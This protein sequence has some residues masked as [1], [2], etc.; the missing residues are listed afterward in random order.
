M[1]RRSTSR[2]S[3]R[4]FAR[5][6]ILA[7]AAGLAAAP[8]L[9]LAQDDEREEIVVTGSRILQSNNN[10]AVPMRTVDSVQI[11]LSGQANV[12]DIIRELPA[13]GLSALTPSNSNFVVQGAGIQTV[14]LRNLGEDRTLVLV[15][16]RR[17]VSG[18]PG[19][20]I[21]DFNSIPTDFIERIDVIT[22]G[23]SAIY[24]SDA[25]A[26]AV[27]IILKDDFEGVSVSGQFGQTLENK[28]NQK[29]SFRVTA[30]SSFADGRGHAIVNAS[31]SQE[32]GVF[33]RD[34]DITA[35]DCTNLAFF[36]DDPADGK[37]C[38]T[39]TF[40]SFPPNT[41]IIIPTGDNT[42]GNR[43]I[44]PA[45]G[46]VRPFVSTEDGF[47]RQS[48]R[49]L[50]TPLERV[51]L[52]TVAEYEIAPYANFFIE[53]TYARTEATSELEP[54]P[55][56]SQDVFGGSLPFCF[57]TNDNDLADT[58]DLSTGVLLSSGVVPQAVRDAVLAAN[59]E[60]TADGAVIGF[61]RRL[62]EVGNRGAS[63]TR[64]TFRIVGGLD[65]DLMEFVEGDFFKS[66]NYE[67]SFNYG[68][69]TENQ[70]SSGQLNVS[71]LREAFNIEDDGAGGVRCANP[72][73]RGEGCVP[74]FIFGQNT[75]NSEA[76]AYI[77][78]PSLRDIEIEQTVGN[79][80]IT[81][82]FGKLP[83]GDAIGFSTG[84]EWRR[85]RSVDIP[86]ALSQTG[87]NAGN[88]QPVQKGSFNV[89]EGFAEIELPIVTG[90]QFFENLTLRGAVRVSDYS[91]VGT[92]VAWSSG[93]EWTPVESVRFRGQYA[94]AVRAP[95]I[96]ELFSA[97][98]E[99]FATVN[100]P[101]AGVTINQATNNPA[102][103]NTTLDINN[104]QNVLNSGVDATTDNS[105]LAQ[106]CLADPIVASRVARDGGFA[107][108]QPEFQ[109]T[110]GFVGGSPPIGTLTEETSR[111]YTIGGVITPRLGNEWIDAFA[112]SVD[113]FNIDIDDAIGI[114]GRQT[115]L[116]FCYS[117]TELSFGSNNQFCSNVVR[118]GMG[119]QIGALNEVNGGTLNIANRHTE[120][121]DAQMNYELGLDRVPGF[122]NMGSPG[123]LFFNATYTYLINLRRSQFG[124]TIDE[125][126]LIG[127]SKHRALVNV[128]YENGPLTF[129][130]D[131]T[132][133]GPAGIDFFEDGDRAVHFKT[134]TFT[135]LQLRYR[136]RDDKVTLVAGIDNVFDNFVPVGGAGGDLGQPVG[137]RTFPEVYEP[138]GRAFY[139]GGR[140]DF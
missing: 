50:S 3:D 54:F 31:W 41:R 88:V 60:L 44:D 55:L 116:D 13:A 134:Q 46:Q 65:G 14:N 53:G 121:V 71:N 103:F 135:D 75:I 84:V 132:I 12:A 122:R 130:A 128:V 4:L 16:G 113:Y 86:D 8:G 138:F 43:V 70:I 24:G 9:A 93:A 90:R 105:L 117:P 94:K 119:P 49:A 40:S 72:V 61:A 22:G 32:E 45:T 30:G 39:P 2:R 52:S 109:G 111:S 120:G 98:G 25:L 127:S 18:L 114:V 6:S 107:I 96:G 85:E 77:N 67:A 126:G 133:I 78:A 92:T 99:T 37:D 102:F 57:D 64:Q 73:A 100:D 118:F 15:N 28:D 131:T 47:N 17:F 83:L 48:V 137:A 104:P 79:A 51:L 10:S 68:T 81:S 124:E 36:T 125:E 89:F 42:V 136:I 11:D 1:L 97:G 91:T 59:P 27:N 82:R 87:Q 19:S 21:V 35:T 26:G 38:F 76:A 110:G 56:S 29:E 34:R 5:T 66:L 63:A 58:C 140:I 112:L 69:T 101:C 33:A 62:T 74:V 80:F 95:N 106:N 23:A 7:L 108:T 129:S 139:V 115:S 20:Q 123:T